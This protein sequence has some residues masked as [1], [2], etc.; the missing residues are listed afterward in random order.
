MPSTGTERAPTSV[1]QI[2]AIRAVQNGHPVYL[3]FMGIKEFKE[4][5][6]IDHLQK[7][8]RVLTG[9][10]R[11]L[12][13]KRAKE[14]A[15][16]IS[17]NYSP[18]TIVLNIRGKAVFQNGKL[19]VPMDV[20]TLDGQHRGTGYIEAFDKG[21][22]P[23]DFPVPLVLISEE[24]VEEQLQFTTINR[25]QMKVNKAHSN[26]NLYAA[27]KI[28]TKTELKDR[29]PE[30]ISKGIDHTLRA[31]K[32]TNSLYD[33]KT[34][35]LGKM[36]EVAGINEDAAKGTTV[37]QA[38]FEDSL[39]SVLEDAKIGGMNDTAVLALLDAFWLGVSG[40]WPECVG[41][42]GK[43]SENYDL[44]TTAG[45]NVLHRVFVKVFGR[46]KK[47]QI[48]DPSVYAK[49]LQ[50]SGWKA[51]DWE[52]IGHPGFTLY[53]EASEELWEAIN[54]RSKEWTVL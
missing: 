39:T 54:A 35:I 42:D 14:F 17:R 12:N 11:R 27:S 3:A 10:Q 7:N 53:A 22:I 38:S 19:I 15:L 29:L 24:Q 1:V 25:T 48:F 31:T 18:T 23:A 44:L 26:Q 46:L 21:L 52:D 20:W 33:S 32:I 47:K 37:K 45:V 6:Y 4:R 36:I 5:F 2:N 40:A 8:A 30:S 51:K 28:I 34:S 50:A 43:L 41:D 16:Y 13:K 49:A 9:S